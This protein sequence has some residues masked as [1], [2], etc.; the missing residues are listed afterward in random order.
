MRSAFVANCANRGDIVFQNKFGVENNGKFIIGKQ[1]AERDLDWFNMDRLI[2]FLNDNGNYT[3]LYFC[4]KT[5]VKNYDKD[6]HYHVVFQG[7]TQALQKFLPNY[8]CKEVYS[9]AGFDD[10]LSGLEFI[11]CS[12]GDSMMCY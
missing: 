4:N 2:N 12:H 11:G 10:F 6:G 9:P 1:P 8:N 5:C 3:E 7:D